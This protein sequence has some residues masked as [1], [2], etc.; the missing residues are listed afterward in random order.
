MHI[1]NWMMEIR[2]LHSMNYILLRSDHTNVD[3]QHC[4][5]V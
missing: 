4:S 5:M 2:F 3:H 1:P